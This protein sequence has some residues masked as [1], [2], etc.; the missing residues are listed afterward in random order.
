MCE[1]ECLKNIIKKIQ[2]K[3]FL[4]SKKTFEGENIF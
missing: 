2:E 1:T 4:L 3:M